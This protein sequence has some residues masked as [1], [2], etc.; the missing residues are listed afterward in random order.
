MGLMDG[1]YGV[2]FGVANEKSIAWG[3]SQALAAEGAQLAFTYAGPILEDRVRPLADSLKSPLVCPCDVTRDDEVEQA[4]AAIKNVFPRVDF[5]VHAVGFA[6]REALKGRYVETTRSDF[7]MALDISCYSLVALA[8][9]VEPLMSEGGS[10]VTLTYYGSQKVMPNYNVMG[11]AKAALEATVR[12]LAWDM[13]PQRIRVN[14]IS[15]G[16]IKTLAAAG[17]SGFRSILHTVAEKSPLR[18]N[19]TQKEV[20]EACLFLCSHLSAATTGDTLFVDCGV[21]VMGV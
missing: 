20:G 10:I 4:F 7:A 18:R 9:A 17:I 5:L 13:G 8:R 14:A 19:V 3:C 16:P 2:I 1:K 11:V 15:A 12:Y 21:N 6:P